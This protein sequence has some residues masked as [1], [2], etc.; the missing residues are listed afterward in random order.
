MELIRARVLLGLTALACKVHASCGGDPQ[1]YVLRKPGRRVLAAQAVPE[2]GL[3]LVPET[4][5][6]GSRLVGSGT[7]S[8]PTVK[9]SGV[10]LA[11]SDTDAFVASIVQ[12][13]FVVP[14]WVVRSTPDEAVTYMGWEHMSVDAAQ[15][16][17]AISASATRVKT[18]K[19]AAHEPSGAGYQLSRPVMENTR[20]VV[21]GE[22]LFT[23][24]PSIPKKREAAP[25]G[26]NLLSKKA[27]ATTKA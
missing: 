24:V 9:L 21:K 13:T 12:D 22:E 8:A 2:G 15:V 5:K 23:Y 6:V 27:T 11:P 7:N 18:K 17:G 1:V 26:L 4:S 20:A 14:A 16:V 10:G 25:A 19:T 3:V